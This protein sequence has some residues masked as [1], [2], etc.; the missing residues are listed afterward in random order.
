MSKFDKTIA[1]SVALDVDGIGDAVTGA[2]F[3]LLANDSGDSLA[4]LVEI[5][6][7]TAN[8]HSGKTITIIGTGPN[9]EPQTEIIAGPDAST[10]TITAK[11]F[12][13]YESITPSATIGADTF[14][15]GWTADSAGPWIFPQNSNHQYVIGFG[16]KVVAGTP[17]YGV[18][19]QF[20]GG[21]EFNHG[22]VTNETTDQIGTIDYPVKGFRLEF[23]AAGSVSM[24]SIQ[25]G[26]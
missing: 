2:A 20:G 25:E 17:T 16:C 23:T 9:G 10:T 22:L 21:Y 1:A 15:I 6:N 4:H 14:D 13:T 3:T 18:Q 7:N 24:Y 26:V 12:L 8:D 5:L 11:Y 19:V